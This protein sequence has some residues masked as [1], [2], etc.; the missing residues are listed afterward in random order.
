MADRERWFR[1]V[2]GQ[3]EVAKLITPDSSAARLLPKAV[4]DDLSLILGLDAGLSDDSRLWRPASQ[5]GIDK[6]TLVRWELGRREPLRGCRESSRPPL[7]TIR[8]MLEWGRRD[9]HAT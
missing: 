4:G 8:A 2:M 5:M 3:D 9:S 7:A 6:A 1:V